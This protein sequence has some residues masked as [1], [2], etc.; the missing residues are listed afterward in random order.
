MPQENND[1]SQLVTR[2]DR[3]DT[4]FDE[5]RKE[6]MASFVLKQVFDMALEARDKNFDELKKDFDDHKQAEMGKFQKYLLIFG[7]ILG[8]ISTAITLLQ[9]FHL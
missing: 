7:G 8:I 6:L 1:F 2:F 4:K 9:H 5:L 3:L